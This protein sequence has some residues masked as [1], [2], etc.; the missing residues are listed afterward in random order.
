[1]KKIIFGLIAFLML[2]AN[3][4]RPSLS[5]VICDVGE[6]AVLTYNFNCFKLHRKSTTCTKRFSICS[7]GTWSIECVSNYLK[8]L[9]NYDPKKDNVKVVIEISDDGKSAVLHFPIELKK[10]SHFISE[11]F[12]NFGFDENYI[13]NKDFTIAKGEYIP[14]LT[15]EEISVT[16]D[17]K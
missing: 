15:N 14:K 2:N 16:V 7:D 9:S 1:M 5:S 4:Q 6:H 10:S 12:E 3:A 13:I 17:L 11:D 8:K